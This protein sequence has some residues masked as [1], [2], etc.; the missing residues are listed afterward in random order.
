MSDEVLRISLP[1]HS[2]N[3]DCTGF[4]EAITAAKGQPIEIDA[5]KSEQMTGRFAQLLILTA[6]SWTTDELLF[7]I[8]EPSE[9]FRTALSRLGVSESLL[10][11]SDA[12]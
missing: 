9:K 11:E 8:V 5:S 1:T 7:K 12:P 6:Q 2:S 4:V 10:K 3:D